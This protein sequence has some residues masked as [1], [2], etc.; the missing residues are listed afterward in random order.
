MESSSRPT[1]TS[2]GERQLALTLLQADALIALDADV[3][4]AVDGLVATA[5]IDALR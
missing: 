1:L 5:S 3:A 4:K 2:Q